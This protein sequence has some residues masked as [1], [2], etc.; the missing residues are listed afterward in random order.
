MTRA[1]HEGLAAARGVSERAAF[2]TRHAGVPLNERQSKV[3]RRLLVDFEG[4]LTAMK[5]AKLAK[6]S[7]DT[8]LRDLKDLIAKGI[9]RKSDKGGRSTTYELRD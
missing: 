7:P 4:N 5:W 1:V 6:C 9:L 2:W 8:A 3:L